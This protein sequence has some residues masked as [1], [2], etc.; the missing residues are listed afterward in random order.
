LAIA[1]EAG[2]KK[3]RKRRQKNIA[4]ESKQDP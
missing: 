1:D 2:A 3:P 4:V